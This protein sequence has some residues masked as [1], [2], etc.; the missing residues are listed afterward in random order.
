MVIRLLGLTGYRL[1]LDQSFIPARPGRDIDTTNFL[2]PKLAFKL[3]QP[4]LPKRPPAHYLSAVLIAE[5]YEVFPLL[6]P[7]C[8]QIRLISIVTEGT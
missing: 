7:M 1:E 5:T 6:Y 4:K 8:G 2:A 3:V